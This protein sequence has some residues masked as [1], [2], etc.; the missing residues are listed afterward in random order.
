MRRIRDRDSKVTDLDQNTKSRLALKS[1]IIRSIPLLCIQ[2]RN[3]SSLLLFKSDRRKIHF[4]SDK[5]QKKSIQQQEFYI[6]RTQYRIILP[7]FRLQL[8]TIVQTRQI[9]QKHQVSHHYYYDYVYLPRR[10]SL[11]KVLTYISYRHLICWFYV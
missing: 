10:I 1:Y 2:Q 3:S 4:S 8:T 9:T 11:R 5:H 7:L 6:V